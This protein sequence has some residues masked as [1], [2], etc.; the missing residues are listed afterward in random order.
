MFRFRR[1]K[2]PQTTTLLQE[3]LKLARDNHHLRKKSKKLE[4]EV[5]FLR[6]E[7]RRIQ[8]LVKDYQEML[9]K[10]KSLRYKKDNKDDDNNN[11]TPKPGGAPKGASRR[12]KKNT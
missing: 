11:H 5:S 3:N 8:L 12:Y 7:F 4:K 1:G 6:Q 2:D 10:K 9:F